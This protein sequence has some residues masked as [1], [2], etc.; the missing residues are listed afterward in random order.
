MTIFLTFAVQALT[1][2]NFLPVQSTYVPLI[3]IYFVCSILC[4]FFS[5][6]WFIIHKYLSDKGS[7]PKWLE[8]VASIVKIVFFFIYMK[9]KQ[10]VAEQK[11]E[12]KTENSESNNHDNQN[13]ATL[14]VSLPNAVQVDSIIN[15]ENSKRNENASCN[16]C[17][18]CSKC[19]ED[20]VK[21]NKKK[22]EKKKFEENVS[23]INFLCLILT[24]IALLILNL[25]IWSLN[26]S[27]QNS[28]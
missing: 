16:K 13:A 1:F 25:V 11:K 22:D 4:T 14:S 2:N 15:I 17:E 8:T 3:I 19:K 27:Y 20:K 7:M 23:A 18:M 28:F 24:F 12:I 9:P 26:L 6:T 10:K 21:E 5:F